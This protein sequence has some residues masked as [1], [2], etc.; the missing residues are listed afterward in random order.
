MTAYEELARF[1][2][3]SKLCDV[4]QALGT[5]SCQAEQFTGEQRTTAAQAARVH[6]PSEEAWRLTVD[7]LRS[8]ESTR[9]EL[10]IKA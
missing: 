6:P 5:G 4:L 2:K 10:G 9:S 7:L 8:R 3:A 1:R